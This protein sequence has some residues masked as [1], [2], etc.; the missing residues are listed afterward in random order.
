MRNREERHPL[1]Q[2][3]TEGAIFILLILYLRI[4][5]HGDGNMPKVT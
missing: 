2:S 3:I 1:E 4:G 5:K